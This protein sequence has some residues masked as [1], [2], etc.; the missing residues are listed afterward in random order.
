MGST[1]GSNYHNNI[2]PMIGIG[3]MFIFS[4]KYKG[5]S[6]ATTPFAGYPYLSNSQIL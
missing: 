5:P 2:Q 3:N 6:D 4:G 1:G